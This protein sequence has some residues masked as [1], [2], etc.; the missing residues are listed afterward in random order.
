MDELA[1]PP[2]AAPLLAERFDGVEGEGEAVPLLPRRISLL[3]EKRSPTLA[4]AM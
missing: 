2:R 1:V 3:L 4:I